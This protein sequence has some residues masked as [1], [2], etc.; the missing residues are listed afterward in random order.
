MPPWIENQAMRMGA[1]L[2]LR[3]STRADLFEDAFDF[4]NRAA[5]LNSKHVVRPS[6]I[7][8]SN[9][10]LPIG[11]ERKAAR[12]SGGERQRLT[13]EQSQHSVPRANA[14]SFDA[15]ARQALVNVNIIRDVQNVPTWMSRQGGRRV[16]RDCLHCS[17]LTALPAKYLDRVGCRDVA[18]KWP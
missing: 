13:T 3:V 1:R 12:T 15:A 14:I 8:G 18:G 5:G 11:R 7:R 17:P 2:M 4:R 10:V 16:A 9:E 6:A